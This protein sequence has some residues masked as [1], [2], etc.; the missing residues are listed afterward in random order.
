MD[1][2]FPTLSSLIRAWN[3]MLGNPLTTICSKTT[4]KKGH[5]LKKAKFGR[6]PKVELGSLDQQS[7][8]L[9]TAPPNHTCDRDL[10]VMSNFGLMS[11]RRCKIVAK[12]QNFERFFTKLG[13]HSGKSDYRFGI[14]VVDSTKFVFTLCERPLR[15][16][17]FSL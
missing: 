17:A 12:G 7:C 2:D 10:G 13:S 11:G 1:L 14:S 15:V 6:P 4:T 5:L 9:P 16:Y 8:T 3:R